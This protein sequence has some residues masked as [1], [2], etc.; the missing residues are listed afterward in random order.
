MKCQELLA[1]DCHMSGGDGRGREG[2]GG[3]GRGREGTGREGIFIFFFFVKPSS[4]PS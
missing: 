3:D 2:T 1:M 4:V